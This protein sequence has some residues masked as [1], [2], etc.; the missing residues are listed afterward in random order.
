MITLSVRTRADRLRIPR[1]IHEAIAPVLPAKL[2]HLQEASA[3]GF[4]VLKDA[5]WVA[6]ID[7]GA[8][9]EP[10]DFS[11]PRFTERLAA[12]SGDRF[13]AEVATLAIDGITV[14][15]DVERYSE[16]RQRRDR[17]DDVAF[18]V[19]VRVDG[20]S[21]EALAET[22]VFALPDGFG[23]P[24]GRRGI[25]LA[26]SDGFKAGGDYKISVIRNSPVLLT[27]KLIDGVWSGA[28]YVDLPHEGA[29]DKRAI[30][31]VKAALARAIGPAIDPW[32]RCW[33]FRPDGY[34]EG[35]WRVH[36]SLGPAAR[37]ALGDSTLV[38]DIPQHQQRLFHADRGFLF[39]LNP[40]KRVFKGK[41]VNSVWSGDLYSN[42]VREAANDMPITDL[43]AT[44]LRNINVALGRK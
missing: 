15:I 3:F 5:S 28:M 13:M 12:L 4:G 37:A 36:L 39:D 10:H 19:R 26:S 9:F 16:A 11:R 23:G 7:S 1:G 44:L 24:A 21:P 8:T 31:S 20:L 27:A 14:G 25:R 2:F 34:D 29:D 35:A 41:F 6:A 22:P 30:G 33:I 40:E 42:G 43:R 38:F 32:V 17:Y 18:H